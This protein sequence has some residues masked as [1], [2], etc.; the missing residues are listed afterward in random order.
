[1]IERYIDLGLAALGAVALALAI[2]LSVTI[3]SVR[4]LSAETQNLSAQ[5]SRGTTLAQVNNNLI[6]LMARTAAER[7]DDQLRNL[8]QSNGVTFKVQPSTKST[9]APDSTGAQQ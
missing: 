8:L 9:A 5:V 2:W 6:Q 7:N 1:V 4:S 3:S